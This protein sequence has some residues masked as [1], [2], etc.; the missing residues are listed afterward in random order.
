M[1]NLYNIYVKAWRNHEDEQ[2]MIILNTY[3]RKMVDSF[4]LRCLNEF[5][6]KFYIEAG[7]D[8]YQIFVSGEPNNIVWEG[9]DLTGEV[10]RKIA[11]EE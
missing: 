11:E 4:E 9:E 10:V 5:H 3:F 7:W 2:F 8:T 6:Y 1:D